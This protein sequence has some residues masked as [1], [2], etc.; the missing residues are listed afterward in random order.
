MSSGSLTYC[1]SS[2]P[3]GLYFADFR[4]NLVKMAQQLIKDRNESG[5]T[6]KSSRRQIVALAVAMTCCVDANSAI[7]AQYWRIDEMRTSIGFKIDAKGF[8]TTHGHFL[9][10][11]GRILIDL[12]HP[13]RSFTSFT[14]DSAS[15][16]VG[17]RS[18]NEFVKSAV[19]L[20]VANFPTL[21]FTSTQV[22]KLDPRTALV[23]GTLTMLGITKPIALK[24]NVGIEPSAKR[25]AV[26]FSATGS[27]KR[28]EFGM[29]F[30]MPLIDDTLEITVKTRALADE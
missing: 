12:E 25:P 20:D 18:F 8:P 30:G 4:M 27:I 29:I 19:L 28:S 13:T 2:P 15:V 21:S 24:V 14:V 3:S 17:S 23:T 22:E 1:A 5:R 9:H 16:D 6:W 10:Y 7:S 11:K 26:A